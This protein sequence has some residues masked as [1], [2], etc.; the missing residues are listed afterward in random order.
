M[1][2][3]QVFR[4]EETHRK[5]VH[6]Q[7]S[8]P[9]K[10]TGL[11]RQLVEPADPLPGG[12]RFERHRIPAGMNINPADAYEFDQTFDDQP[13][14]DS[15][16]LRQLDGSRSLLSQLPEHHMLERAPSPSLSND[17]VGLYFEDRQTRGRQLR[18]LLLI[19]AL[20]SNGR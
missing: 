12:R 16:Q 19:S 13:Q 2:Q 5:A 17:I 3:R 20:A 15:R 1:Y 9:L 7:S 6:A 4:L 11:F 8:P 18:R 10:I 14:R